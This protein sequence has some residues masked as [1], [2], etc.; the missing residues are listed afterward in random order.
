MWTVIGVVAFVFLVLAVVN[1]RAVGDFVNWLRA[2]VGKGGRALRNMDPLANYQQSIDDAVE[3]V[4]RAKQGMARA[5]A[6]I[7]SVERQVDSGKAEVNRLN[8]RIQRAVDDGATVQQR[9]YALLLAD[10]EKNLKTNEEQLKSHQDAYNDFVTEVR[11]QQDKIVRYQREAESLGVRLEMS[12][13]NKEFN[14]FRQSFSVNN[15]SL[16]GLSVQR[17]AV[18]KQIDTNNACSQVEKD[19]GGTNYKEEDEAID[20]QIEADEILKRFKR[21]TSA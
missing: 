12:Q 9:E 4:K 5:V 19:V 3:A 6:L 1:R 20:R 15:G 11:Q 2:Q 7:K 8:V 18:L 10:S 16:N 13:A 21:P 14:E 17:E